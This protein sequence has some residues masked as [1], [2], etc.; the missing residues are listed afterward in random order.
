MKSVHVSGKR[1]RAIARATVRDGTGVVRVNS[2]LLD[3]YMPV[4]A[5]SLVEEPLTIGSDIAKN[6]NI[7]V[8]VIGGGWHSQAEAARLVVAKGL[9]A[10]SGSKVLRQKFLEYDRHLLVQDKRRT[11]PSKP[12]DSKPRAARQKSYR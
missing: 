2:L 11:E 10:Y 12:N 8:Q 4:L 5:R 3:A 7:D 6:V 9:V 1:K